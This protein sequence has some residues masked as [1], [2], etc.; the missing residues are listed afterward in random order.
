MEEYGLQEVLCREWPLRCHLRQRPAWGLLCLR[1]IAII[2]VEVAKSDG[3]DLVSYNGIIVDMHTLV[4]WHS[5]GNPWNGYFSLTSYSII[6]VHEQMYISIYLYF[7]GQNYRNSEY[8]SRLVIQEGAEILPLDNVSFGLSFIRSFPDCLGRSYLGLKLPKLSVYIW[9][10][11]GHF[12]RWLYA[13]DIPVYPSHL[14]VL[15][16]GRGEACCKGQGLVA[17]RHRHWLSVIVLPL[18]VPLSAKVYKCEGLSLWAH[19]WDLRIHVI[20]Q[21]DHKIC[22]HN[23]LQ[24]MLI[25]GRTRFHASVMIPKVHFE[26]AEWPLRHGEH[27]YFIPFRDTFW[28][29]PCRM[30][31]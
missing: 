21:V 17:T 23:W 5:F 6:Q 22:L 27:W 1:H 15:S 18:R 2:P 3:I 11:M 8:G 10:D 13:L 28:Y 14:K 16:E 7:W 29:R 25:C 20:L 31:E 26:C 24:T 4:F 9:S 19:C 30:F 12:G